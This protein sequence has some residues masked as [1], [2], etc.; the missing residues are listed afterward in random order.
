MR[1][2][3]GVDNS[4]WRGELGGS[5]GAGRRFCTQGEEGQEADEGEGAQV[6]RQMGSGHG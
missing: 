1:V 2:P 6:V 5:G 3:V 4:C